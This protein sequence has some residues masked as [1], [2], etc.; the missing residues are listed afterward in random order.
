MPKLLVVDDES[1]I[2]LSIKAVFSR[3]DVTVLGAETAKEGM[4]LALEQSP[5]RHPAGHQA[6]NCLRART[7]S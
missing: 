7:I 6:R 3:T 2:R 4:R 5:R 1:S